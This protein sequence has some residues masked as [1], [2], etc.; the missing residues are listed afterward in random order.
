MFENFNLPFH[1]MLLNPLIKDY[2]DPLINCDSYSTFDETSPF[3]AFP[4]YIIFICEY[5]LTIS[6]NI[7]S[8]LI[9]LKFK[10]CWNIFSFVFYEVDPHFPYVIINEIDVVP[11][12]SNGS[13]FVVHTYEWIISKGF[14]LTWIIWIENG[15][16]TYFF[17]WHV[18]KLLASPLLFQ[19][20]EDF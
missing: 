16:L 8:L 11:T 4:S 3:L 13:I 10:K 12:S 1:G 18:S 6:S 17:N 20:W 7:T 2:C 15:C 9:A 5:Q 19:I 14:E